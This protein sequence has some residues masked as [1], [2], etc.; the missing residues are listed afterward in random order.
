MDHDVVGVTTTERDAGAA[1]GRDAPSMFANGGPL[2]R[3]Y[4]STSAPR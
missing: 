4:S 1:A 2:L 3:K